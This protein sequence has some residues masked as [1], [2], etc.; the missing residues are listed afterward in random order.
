MLDFSVFFQLFQRQPGIVAFKFFQIGTVQLQNVQCF[1]TQA[2]NTLLGGEY[3]VIF[4]ISL[5]NRS[6]TDII[7]FSGVVKIITR[8]GGNHDLI[9][10]PFFDHVGNQIFRMTKSV[11]ICGINQ[12]NALIQGRIQ[13]FFRYF[14]IGFTPVHPAD[15]PGA[16]TNCRDFWSPFA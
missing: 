1:H 15:G 2:F 5:D 16:K 3:D 8:L 14:V 10:F 12:S 6:V 13:R 11:H 7:L 9:L 4:G